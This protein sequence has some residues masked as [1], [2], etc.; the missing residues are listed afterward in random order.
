MSNSSSSSGIGAFFEDYGLILFLIAIP[1]SGILCILQLVFSLDNMI[2]L[3]I[4]LAVIGL[5]LVGFAIGSFFEGMFNIGFILMFI[6]G[7]AVL[8][9]AYFLAFEPDSSVTQWF[10]N[11]YRPEVAVLKEDQFEIVLDIDPHQYQSGETGSIMIS[12]ENLSEHTLVL[13]SVMFE[14][15]DQFYEGFVVDYDSADPPINNRKEKIGNTTALF[16]SAEEM[17]ITPGEKYIV[18]VEIVANKPGD[19]SDTFYIFP[20]FDTLESEALG[21]LLDH[22]EKINLVILP[23]E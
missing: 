6:V 14:T 5:A 12:F 22:E 18:K 4:A 20:E 8:V 2:L 3:I 13:N 23:E 15:R 10:C 11:I 19:Y 7:A 9:L 17:I 1:I 16:F 21:V